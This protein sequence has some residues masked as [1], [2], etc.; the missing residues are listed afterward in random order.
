MIKRR[1]KATVNGETIVYDSI[2]EAERELHIGEKRIYRI[3][4][5]RTPVNEYNLHYTG[6]NPT[7]T[8]FYHYFLRRKDY[9]LTTQVKWAQ[10][11]AITGVYSSKI[12]LAFDF[13]GDTAEIGD[14]IITRKKI[15][16]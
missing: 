14:F 8:E 16:D 6:D 12:K 2:A 15:E 13:V 7:K 9:N 10:L 5:G 4:N 3:L 1:V 11:S